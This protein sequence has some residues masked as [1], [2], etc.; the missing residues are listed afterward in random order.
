M[1]IKAAG[2]GEDGA[3][4]RVSSTKLG[5]FL[6]ALGM[7][8]SSSPAQTGDPRR[9]ID[10]PVLVTL[11]S[12]RDLYR[13]LLVF[14]PTDRDPR[15]LAQVRLFAGAGSELNQRQ[16]IL[17]PLVHRSSGKP[18]GAGQDPANFGFMQSSAAAAARSRFHIASGA[19]TAI[20]LGKD[21]GE[22][23][24]SNHPIAYEQLRDTIDA[25]PMRQEEMR[26]AR[27]E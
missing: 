11:D 25:M 16:V 15:F 18:T 9:M 7:L 2:K 13:P 24:R 5:L 14:T 3:T 20:Q 19:F 6:V 17:V 27:Q 12:M 22:K 4:R 1:I 8:A 23:L 10:K 26:R 21:G